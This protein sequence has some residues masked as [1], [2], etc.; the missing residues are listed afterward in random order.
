MRLRALQQRCHRPWR[1][2][3]PWALWG[4]AR[5]RILASPSHNIRQAPYHHA[6]CPELCCTPAGGAD[7]S[8]IILHSRRMQVEPASEAWGLLLPCLVCPPLAAMAIISC[9][10][11]RRNRCCLGRLTTQRMALTR[12]S[13]ISA[14]RAASPWRPSTLRGGT[15]GSPAAWAASSTAMTTSSSSSACTSTSATGR[16]RP[17]QPP[18]ACVLLHGALAWRAPQSCRDSLNSIQSQHMSRVF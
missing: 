14:M 7:R 4:T 11:L 1:Q 3:P 2:P 16:P 12:Q 15:P 9:G 10:M 18:A 6:R 17:Q 8:T 5:S 13:R